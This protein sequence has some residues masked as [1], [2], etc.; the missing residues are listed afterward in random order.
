[1]KPLAILFATSEMAPWVKTGG[2]GDVAAALPAALRRAG[3]DIRV[4]MPYYPALAAAFPDVGIGL[5]G[6]VVL[7]R[8]PFI[9][10]AAP[11]HWAML[12]PLGT[13]ALFAVYQILTRKLAG[14]DDP[15]TTI[16]HTSFAASLVTSA[17]L[18]GSHLDALGSSGATAP[19]T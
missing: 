13:A 18:P 10:G 7:L 14:V 6:V 5:L 17:T 16:L 12:L 4:L 8:P 11:V 9:F 19:L 15:R 2:L 3:H 1:M